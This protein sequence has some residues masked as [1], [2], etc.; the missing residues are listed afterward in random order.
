MIDKEITQQEKKKRTAAATG[1]YGSFVQFYFHCL[2]FIS[3]MFQVDGFLLST[4]SSAVVISGWD[5]VKLQYDVQ[6]PLHILF[7]PAILEK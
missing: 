7:Q 5:C 3:L 4:D 2:G 6:W 1:I